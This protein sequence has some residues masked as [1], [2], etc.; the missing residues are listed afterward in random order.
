MQID[1]KNSEK[2]QI[3]IYLLFVG[4]RPF[5]S[6][7][8][9]SRWSISELL[10]MSHSRSCKPKLKVFT[11]SIIQWTFDESIGSNSTCLKFNTKLLV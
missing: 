1:C 7:K 3:K 10:S 4:S 9:L 6:K 11:Q 5:I 2:D 8:V